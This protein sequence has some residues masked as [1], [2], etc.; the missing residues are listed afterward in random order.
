[1]LNY[2]LELLLKANNLL[3]LVGAADKKDE[4]KVLEMSL[5][6]EDVLLDKSKLVIIRLDKLYM[7]VPFTMT[8]IEVRMRNVLIN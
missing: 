2:V 7:V 5:N 3:N 4:V 1:M 8:K 6:R